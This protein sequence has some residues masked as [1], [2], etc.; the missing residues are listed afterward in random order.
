MPSEPTADPARDAARDPARRPLSARI[1][2]QHPL[3]ALFV[4][5]T[6]IVLGRVVAELAPRSPGARLAPGAGDGAGTAEIVPA[7]PVPAGSLGTWR[8]R[9]V[10]SSS[11]IEIGGGV[12]VQISPYWGWTAPQT[13]D[14]LAPGFTTATTSARRARLA[15]STTSLHAIVVTVLEAPLVAGDTVVV[16]YGDTD[17]GKQIAASAQADLYAERSQEFVVKV[18]GDGDG[19]FAE[20]ARSPA[21]EVAPRDPTRLV[22]AGPATARPGESMRVAV[23]FLDPFDNRAANALGTVRLECDD[24]AARLPPAVAFAPSDS[25][26]RFVS[27]TLFGEG[28]QALRAIEEEHGLR[29]ESP[30]ILVRRDEMGVRLLWADLHGHSGLSDGS[31]A[32]RDFYRYARDVMNLDVAALTDHDHHGLRPLSV[33]DWT[34]IQDAA[35][36]SYRPDTFVTFIAYEWTNWTSGHRNVYFAGEEGALLSAADPAFDA[37]EE[38]WAALDS[39]GLDAMTIAHHPAGGAMATDW[40][41]APPALWESLVEIASAHGSSEFAGCPNEVRGPRPGSHVVDAL[42]RGYRLG[43]IA[44]GD[45]HTGHPGRAYGNSL[46]GL[47]G[48][49]AAACTREAVWEALRARRV[50]GTTGAR[51]LLEF[52]A[53]GVPMGGTLPL[54]AR[55][56]QVTFRVRAVGTQPIERIDLVRDGRPLATH[57]GVSLDETF[58][59]E[60]ERPSRPGSWTYARVVQVDGETAWSSPIWFVAATETASAR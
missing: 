54:G 9:Y 42:A 10:A 8:V 41:I 7:A 22:V 15:V 45:S 34:A 46:G 43:L 49:Y 50:Y 5:F 39:L 17:E 55:R 48:I 58:T 52:D 25:G 31:G 23:A 29:A 60:E 16:V 1:F 3:P 51:I 59:F 14:P 40:S 37:P 53:D 57:A 11:G 2:L 30:P 32:P 13:E 21:V 38:L 26:A 44:A 36:G 56:A 18:D 20:I 19:V 4:L 27:V 24:P 28:R 12:V 6:L 35:N 33:S 47:A